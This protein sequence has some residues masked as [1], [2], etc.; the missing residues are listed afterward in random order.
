MVDYSQ[1]GLPNSEG[2]DRSDMSRAMVS[3][4]VAVAAIAAGSTLVGVTLTQAGE[5]WRRRSANNTDMRKWELNSRMAAY[6]NFFRSV[7][8]RVSALERLR[9]AVHAEQA[10]AM[11]VELFPVSNEGRVRLLEQAREDADR[12]LAEMWAAYREVRLIGPESVSDKARELA[13]HY[14]TQDPGAIEGYPPKGGSK[15]EQELSELV[16]AS[17]KDSA[18]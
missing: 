10:E 9:Q 15:L 18:T 14:D 16:Q 2:L 7:S 6:T 4:T 1:V 13:F 11:Q 8:L 3:S 12:A 5:V 17:L